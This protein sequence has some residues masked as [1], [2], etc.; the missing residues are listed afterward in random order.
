MLVVDYETMLIEPVSGVSSEA[1]IGSSIHEKQE[2]TI[3][4]GPHGDNN[5]TE[6]KEG[7]FWCLLE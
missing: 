3:C 7:V 5:K 1:L 6:D 2:L 4:V